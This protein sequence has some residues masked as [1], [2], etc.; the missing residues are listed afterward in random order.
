[1]ATTMLDPLDAAMMTAESLSNPLH[2]AA[3]L[4]MSPPADADAG[5]IDQLYRVMLVASDSLDPRL[6][7][8]PHRDLGTGGVWV[9]KHAEHVD[10]GEHCRLETLPAGSGMTALWQ[11][12][13]ELHGQ[14]LDRSRPMWM[15]YL[16]AGL[17]DGRFALYVKIHHTVVDGVA[18]LQMIAGGL[19][20]D[21]GMRSMPP[22]F[23][24]H[25]DRL[26]EGS[27]HPDFGLPDPIRA[28][29]ELVAA[30][31]SGAT[32]VER[33]VSGE[34]ATVVR[35]LTSDTTV[36]ALSAPYTRFNGRL[37][38]ER[39]VVAGSWSRTRIRTIQ[40]KAG[41]T[42]NDVVVAVVSGVLRNWLLDH[43]EL[44]DSSLV[45]I[46]PIT[47]RGRAE[48]PD[49]G[50]GNMFGAWLVPLGTNL[51]SPVERLSL[52][53]RSMTEAKRQVAA[54][55]P[56]VS[57]LLLAPSIAPT[58]LQPMLPFLPKIRTGY[59]VP[60]SHVP[61]PRAEMYWNG[62]HVEEI[63]PVSAVY[64]GQALNVTTC[65]YADRVC[66]GYVAG[67][68][69]MPEIDT[70]IPLTERTLSELEAALGL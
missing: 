15:C 6:R 46:C 34:V 62:A 23:A 42:G 26:P 21:P 44:P 30:A 58:V 16:I 51:D 61:G 36:A 25:R 39:A 40:N 19:S 2:V 10:V 28:V 5:Y 1:M 45:A 17:D 48:E 69:Q 50:H 70:V 54:R 65:S 49:S 20:T 29:R 7:R 33:I 27:A 67:R 18:G 64:D 37:S 38:R 9:W 24:T 53:H 8:Y 32:T 31:A 59:N 12:I 66:F 35:E 68:D 57:M 3:V 52:I 56:G 4:I 63:Y 60:I 14:P 47:A 13:S 22:F 41:V 55:G 11:L 43:H